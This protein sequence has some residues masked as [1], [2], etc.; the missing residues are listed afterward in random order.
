LIDD[1][2]IDDVAIEYR[3]RNKPACRQLPCVH[4]FRVTFAKPPAMSLSSFFV[5]YSGLF[6]DV[7]LARRGETLW[8]RL[9]LTPCSSIRQLSG[10]NAEQRAYYRFL[11]NEKVSETV[12]IE[13]AV[14]RM[15]ELSTD[16]HLLCIQD[17][18]EINLIKH[19][20]R[21]QSNSGLGRSDN[22]ES[23]CCFKVHPGLV[24]DAYNA[25]LLG[26]S[27]IKVFHR[28]EE[29]P[30]RIER[31]Y[32]KQEIQEK[33]S[34]K[35][36]E[37]AQQSKIVLKDA[38]SVTFIEDREGDIYEQFAIV[39]DDK[40]HLLVRSRTTRKLSDGTSLYQSIQNAPLAGTYQVDIPTDKRK[41]QYKRTATIELRFMNCELQCPT[42]LRG[43]GYPSTIEVCCIAAKEIDCPTSN[44][45]DWKLITTHKISTWE[46]AILMIDWYGSRW[47]I[48]QLFRLLKKQGFGVEESELESGW[49]IRKLVIMQMTALLKI[50]QMNIA[51][52]APEGGQPI[53]EV[54]D[55]RE[56][57]VLH[58]INKKFQGKTV[59]LGN[60]NDPL[61][62][63]WATWIIGRL[64]GWKGYDSQGPPGVIILKRGLE[65]L[66]Y[67]IEGIELGKD[68][69]TQ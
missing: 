66:G 50:L 34:F 65:R 41:N 39:P 8:N 24:I 16:R 52:A 11:H 57:Q 17:T 9:S 59:K 46:E 56:I 63:K 23:G 49:A 19:Q 29:L 3:T 61:T 15:K 18:S 27:H 48:E 40:F 28:P 53:D 1:Y 10:N 55:S 45:I 64:G 51:Y 25:H 54:F 33:E 35:W 38:A 26:Y 5:D 44:P 37:V 68:M 42:N 13:E 22:S 7:R 32:K 43:K 4:K 12:L 58:L 20:D 36:I 21:L 2:L 67:I 69:Y 47:Y 62:T 31:K 6:G 60:H 30:N 14:G